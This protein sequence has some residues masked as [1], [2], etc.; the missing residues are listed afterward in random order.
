MHPN[1]KHGS[2]GIDEATPNR[3]RLL[4][5]LGTA[6]LATGLGVQTAAA[7][8]TSVQVM[9][10]DTLP[11][12]ESRQLAMSVTETDRTVGV[13]RTLADEGLSASP[14]DTVSARLEL[15]NAEALAGRDPIVTTV[16][17]RRAG[18]DTPDAAGLLFAVT[19][20]KG[21]RRVVAATFGASAVGTRAPMATAATP[22]VE[23]TILSNDG[24]VRSTRTTTVEPT[25]VELPGQDEI[26]CFLCETV[27]VVLCSLLGEFDTELCQQLCGDSAICKTACEALASYIDDQFC[28]APESNC[29]ALG[30]CPSEQ[31]LAGAGSGLR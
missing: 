20:R 15:A 29:T 14:A 1:D 19:V 30:L 2:D 4:R 9:S 3:R 24:R 18:T 22:P 31:S 5:G 28:R 26:F 25:D 7:D 11:E 23:V 8:G 21:D 13:R 27:A 10:T 6:S 17:Y 12:T 16:P